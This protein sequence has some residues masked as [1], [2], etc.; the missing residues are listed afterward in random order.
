MV[1]SLR[2][3]QPSFRLATSPPSILA[4]KTRSHFSVSTSFNLRRMLECFWHPDDWEIQSRTSDKS[5]HVD[6]SEVIRRIVIGLEMMNGWCY[7]MDAVIL[8][9][10]RTYSSRDVTN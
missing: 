1:A 7:F 2:Q 9:D 3:T 8:V 10:D 4:P 5:E 6:G